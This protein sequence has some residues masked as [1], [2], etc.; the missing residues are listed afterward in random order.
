MIRLAPQQPLLFDPVNPQT[1]QIETTYVLFL[2]F[3][4]TLIFVEGIIL[5]TKCGFWVCKETYQQTN[6][7]ASNLEI[8][9]NLV[10]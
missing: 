3:V 9:L 6:H 5:A 2:E 8:H 7:N 1:Q 10:S 4:G